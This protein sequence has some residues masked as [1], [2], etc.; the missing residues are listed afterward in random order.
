LGLGRH[1]HSS[2]RYTLGG[3]ANGSFGAWQYTAKVDVGYPL[4]TGAFTFTPI[5]SLTYSRLDQGAYSESGVGA[6]SVSSRDIDSFKTGLGLKAAIPLFN[7]GEYKA[8]LQAR[9]SW[10]HEFGNVDQ[11][12]TASFV[13]V[14]TNFTTNGVKVARDGL[15]LGASV[16]FANIDEGVAQNLSFSYDADLKSQYLNHTARV[17]ARFD[18]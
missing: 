12:T 3:I 17:Q 4:Q 14:G 1:N 5:G 13:G 15:N 8:T 10:T 18:F 6:L 9:T 7:E 16:I 11:D 2:K